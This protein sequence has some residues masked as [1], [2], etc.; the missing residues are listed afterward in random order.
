[1]KKEAK[2]IHRSH[3]TYLP[4]AFPA[5]YYG[6]PNGKIYM[7]FS[8]FYSVDIGDSG[9]EFV[10]AEHKDLKYD[11]DTETIL[12]VRRRE[13]K[14]TFFSEDVD[15]PNSKFK[16]LKTNRNFRSYAEAQSFI[17]ERAM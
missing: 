4:T 6:M 12:P 14:R 13:I 17:H 3:A 11:Y 7:I 9:I 2:L 1:M 8:R 5:H 10:F 15:S 16:I